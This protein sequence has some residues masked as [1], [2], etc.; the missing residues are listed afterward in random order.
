MSIIVYSP[1]EMCIIA[2]T[3]V[4][5]T[6]DFDGAIGQASFRDESKI[7]TTDDQHFT[8][9]FEDTQ[10]APFIPVLTAYL[11]RYE[12][13]LLKK[14][15]KLPLYEPSQFSVGIM[16]KRHMYRVINRKDKIT[17][18]R[19]L[20]TFCNHC[21][22]ASLMYAAKLPALEVWKEL[23]KMDEVYHGLTPNVVT[24]KHLKLIKK[25]KKAAVQPDQITLEG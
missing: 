11:K 14:E 3:F 13:G 5:H 1:S 4:L 10:A 18:S 6:D 12:L 25:Q 2:D 8:Y 23:A 22:N 24:N 21:D 19:R 9:C 7:I 16:S 17:I 20:L 15:D